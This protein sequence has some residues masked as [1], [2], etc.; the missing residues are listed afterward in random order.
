MTN[1]A[2]EPALR[3]RMRRLLDHRGVDR[4]TIRAARASSGGAGS[5]A[6]DGRHGR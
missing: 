6:A 3:A 5:G 2:R 4:R 1:K